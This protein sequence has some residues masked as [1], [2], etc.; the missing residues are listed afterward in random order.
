VSV[1]PLA[2][3]ITR[4]R[5]NDAVTSPQQPVDVRGYLASEFTARAAGRGN[6]WITLQDG[7]AAPAGY[8]GPSTPVQQLK[9]NQMRPLALAS[10]DF[11]EDGVP[12]LV[13]GY[14]GTKD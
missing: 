13:A 11:D 2:R 14:A 7:H 8:Q 4:A 1:L 10:A 6:P 9:D 5:A 12:D 3:W